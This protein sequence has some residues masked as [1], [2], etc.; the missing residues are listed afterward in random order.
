MIEVPTCAP[1]RTLAVERSNTVVTGGPL[2]TGGAGAVVYVVAAVVPSP[3]VHT[4]ALV[5][6]VRVV[7]RAAILAC[8]G[9][10]LALIDVIQAELT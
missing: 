5:A 3:A 8:V 4:H 6:A 10:E 9:H 7:A 1:V 2:I